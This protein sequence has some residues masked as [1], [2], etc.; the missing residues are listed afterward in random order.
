MGPDVNKIQ[1]NVHCGVLEAA[2]DGNPVRPKQGNSGS[3]F[4]WT[5]GARRALLGS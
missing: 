2:P 4:D 3:G 5:L 1:Q